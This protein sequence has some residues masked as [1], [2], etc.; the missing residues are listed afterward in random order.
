MAIKSQN[1]VYPLLLTIFHPFLKGFK[2]VYLASGFDFSPD[3]RVEVV[4]GF[5]TVLSTGPLVSI[6]FT[7]YSL[8]APF[9][10]KSE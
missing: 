1:L 4:G 8:L 2:N 10:R 7:F 6:L 9:T 3:G 5:P